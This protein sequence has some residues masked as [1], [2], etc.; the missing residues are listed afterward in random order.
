MNPT[1]L[2]RL[3]LAFFLGT[4]VCSGVAFSATPARPNILFLFSDDQRADT[5]HALGN[6]H[7]QTPHLDRLARE[8]TAFTQAHILGALQGA[9]CVPSR[10]MMLSGRSLFRVREDLRDTPTW[11][12]QLG[13]A[14]WKTFI[15]GKWH[16][17]ANSLAAS[18]SEG[19]DVFLGGM[20]DQNQVKV[21]DLQPDG[22]LT[23][24][25]KAS[26]PSSETFADSAIRFLREP[27][28]DNQ[29]FCLYV[30]FTSPHDP[31]TPPESFA[32]RYSSKPPPLPASFLPQHPFDNGELGVRDEK[33]LPWPR[34]AEAV[35]RELAS[36]YGMITHLDAQI[37]RILDALREAH[38]DTNTLIVFA[39]DNGLAIGSHGLLGKQNL[40][41]HSTRVP[42]LIAGPG[43]PRNRRVDQLVTLHQLAAT[44]CEFTRV[45]TPEGSEG[46]SLLPI[47][48]GESPTDPTPCVLL[49]A[50]RDLQRAV[51]DG[52]WKLIE[53]PKAKR[54]QLFNLHR[55][56]N[57]LRDLIDE[58]RFA[59][60]RS[61]ML[62]LLRNQQRVS[63]DP[64]A[65]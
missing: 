54:F 61:R 48:R 53:Y 31:R 58:S 6:R 35:R 57:E 7:I 32:T 56:P 22:T 64:L 59:D 62:S 24:E 38:L 44:L 43:L 8:G 51:T 27:R 28:R 23:P 42:L 47:L 41:E 4:L 40:Y 10:A 29:P 13:R 46:R 37:G 14:G 33:L 15:T 20:T 55:D 52:R 39:G 45:P 63:A 65:P 34:T 21:R 17:G 36:Y 5:L 26:G 30:A 3:V 1:R 2:S 12:A 49:T 60:E 50:Y 19:R 25:R 9:V 16:N 18:F 11:P